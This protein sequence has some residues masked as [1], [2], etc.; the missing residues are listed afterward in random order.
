MTN[1]I[2]GFSK[3]SKLKLISYLITK[4]DGTD[5]SHVYIRLYS[6][7]LNRNLIYQASG[8]KVNF[9]GFNSFLSHNTV[10]ASFK[11]KIMEEQKIKLLQKAIDYAERPYS[12]K[13]LIGLGFVRGCAFFGKRIKNP[14]Y[15]GDQAFICSELVANLL[16]DLGYEFEDLNNVSPKDIYEV[17]KNG[18]NVQKQ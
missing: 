8:L 2:V 10:V 7:S 12:I 3:P 11:I 14:F 5:F 15:D 18:Q 4:L 9:I 6:E 17:L 13:Q 16:V 1:L